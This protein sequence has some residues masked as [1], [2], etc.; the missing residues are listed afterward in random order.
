MRCCWGAPASL[1]QCCAEADVYVSRAKFSDALCPSCFQ[2]FSDALGPNC[3]HPTFIGARL[4]GFIYLTFSDALVRG[5]TWP[6]FSDTLTL[7]SLY[8]ALGD[9]PGPN[10]F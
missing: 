10:Y 5:R 3:F 7:A 8:T 9:A 4:P 1:P 6:T 2:K